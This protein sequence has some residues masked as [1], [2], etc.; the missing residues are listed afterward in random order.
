MI[1]SC[2]QPN[3]TKFLARTVVRTGASTNNYRNHYVNHH[4]YILH[5]REEERLANLSKKQ[6]IT[7]PTPAKSQFFTP[8]S[9]LATP[10][11]DEFDR[12]QHQF[13]QLLIKFVTKNNLLFRIVDQETTIE[14]F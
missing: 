3:C 2:S 8:R 9:S 11:R 7:Q 10:D 12:Q 14:L 1:V 13:R 5:S 4:P 6:T